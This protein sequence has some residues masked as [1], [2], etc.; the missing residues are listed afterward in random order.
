MF[1]KQEQR[2]PSSVINARLWKTVKWVLSHAPLAVLCQPFL[3]QRWDIFWP[4]WEAFYFVPH[5]YV[6]T[7]CVLGFILPTPKKKKTA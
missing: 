3:T 4:T 7:L 1:Y 2:L 5:V 6:F